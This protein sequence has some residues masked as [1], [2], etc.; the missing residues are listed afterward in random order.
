MA[1]VNSKLALCNYFTVKNGLLFI[2]N[3]GYCQKV[4]RGSHYFSGAM[5]L[6]SVYYSANKKTF[7]NQQSNFLKK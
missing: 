1:F 6:S 5:G 7:K 3:N 4:W 2:T